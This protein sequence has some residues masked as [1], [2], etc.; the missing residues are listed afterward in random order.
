MHD[1]LFKAAFGQPDIA[2]S[3]LA[4]VLPPDI[5]AHL[6]LSTLVVTPGSFVDEELRHAH[7]DLL[8]SVR[9]KGDARDPEALVYVLFEHQSSFDELMPFRFLRYT[10]RV[11]ERWLRDNAPATKLPLV[12]PVLLHHGPEGWRAAPELA[13]MF[14]ANPALLD[15][16]RPFQPH[17]RFLLDDLALLSLENLASRVASELTR[18]VRLALWSSRSRS[19]L[20]GAAP[21]MGAII[22]SLGR[23]ERT[24]ELLIQ[25]H[26]YLLETAPPD[27]AIEEVRTILL[28]MAGPEGREDVMNAGEQLRQQGREQGFQQGRV[29]GLRT[30]IAAVL[31]ARGLDCSQENREKVAAC[32]DVATLTRWHTRAVTAPSE[33][34]VFA[35]V[36]R[37]G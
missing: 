3:E 19:R 6:D 9:I 28:G 10:V 7:T 33:A 21:H 32:G 25:L 23:E 5:L 36:G 18:L 2:R 29:E 16:T 27:V 30:A 24:R 15:A 13:A 11:W 37:V 17:F 14:D 4:L 20:L 12:L 1:A 34:E 26:L 31:S 35:D 22:A 8:Y